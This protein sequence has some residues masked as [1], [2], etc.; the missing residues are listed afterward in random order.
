MVEL[1]RRKFFWAEM[2]ND[3]QEYVGTWPTCQSYKR[4]RHAQYGLLYVLELLYVTSDSI[5][6]DLIVELP[7][8]N[9]CSQIWVIIDRIT[10][11]AHFIPMMDT[12]KK[13]NDLALIFAQ[14][15]SVLHGLSTE[16]VSDQ[17]RK[18]TS[19]LWSS[20]CKR[21]GKCQKMRTSF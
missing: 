17:D 20:L 3:I 1:I 11:M 21:Q 12:K 7:L 10:R 8:S 2:Y 6:I 15:I 16:I 9:G 14:I 13:E 19:D 18:F 4:P 5:T